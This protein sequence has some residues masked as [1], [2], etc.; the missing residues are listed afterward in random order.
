[1]IKKTTIILT[2]FLSLLFLFGSCALPGSAGNPEN[3]TGGDPV[4]DTFT[5]PGFN[6][7]L[8][9]YRFGSRVLRKGSKGTDVLELQIRI[10]GWASNSAAKTYVSIDGDFGPGT[11]NALKRFQSAYGLSPDGVAGSKTYSVL[12]NL[13]ASDGSTAH[14]NFS[15]FYCKD[16][17]KFNYG[18]VSSSRVKENV[19]RLMWK[20]EALR[21]KAGNRSV[22]IT[23]GFRNISYNTRIG[24]ASDSK[25]MYGIAADIQVSGLS[26]YQV[27][28][29]AKT[30]GFS[31]IK[32][33]GTFNHVDSRIEYAYGSQV[34]WWAN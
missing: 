7:S 30:C 6:N 4:L 16:G 5:T 17:N 18:K 21:K 24:G 22:S 28:S 15:E 13:Q 26:V 14:F 33:Y 2:S 1:M 27:N 3:S 9:G 8:A 34:W 12:N 23:S 11:E 25:H 32:R 29:L 10:A 20:L 19:R 31:G